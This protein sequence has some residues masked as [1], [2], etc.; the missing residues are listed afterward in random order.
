M[1]RRPS[2][3]R[4]NVSHMCRATL[5]HITL[6]AREARAGR[7]RD[8]CLCVF[9]WER[10]RE[11]IFFWALTSKACQGTPLH[12]PDVQIPAPTVIKVHFTRFLPS[13][14]FPL[15]YCV[16]PWLASCQMQAKGSVHLFILPL[17][18]NSPARWIQILSLGPG[19][20][21]KLSP[22]STS[23]CLGKLEAH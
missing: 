10:E 15:L 8:D 3:C 16:S 12:Q 11:K 9:G 17:L 18:H 20:Q 23:F 14:V 5:F 22:S 2:C 4:I 19:C 13:V 1:H 7:Q 6:C 21:G